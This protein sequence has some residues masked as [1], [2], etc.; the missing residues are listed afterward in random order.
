[1]TEID[2]R[3]YGPLRDI[4][5]CGTVKLELPEPATGRDAFAVLAARYPDL[6]PWRDRVRLA[7]NLQYVPLETALAPGD[8]ICFIPPVSGG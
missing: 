7:L 8:E 1:M 3:F 2:I 5:P 6:A 4:V